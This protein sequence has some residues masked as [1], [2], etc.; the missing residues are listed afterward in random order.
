MSPRPLIRPTLLALG[1]IA[2]FGATERVSAQG[3]SE[4]Q[5]GEIRQV[6]KEYLVSNPEVIQEAIAE[7][8]RRQ[9]EAQRTAQAASIRK[10][11]DALLDPSTALV[12]GNPNGDVTLIEFS[13]YNCSYC[14]KAL[15][16][17]RTLI[18]TDPKLRIIIRDLEFIGGRYSREANV[19]ALAARKQ[20]SGD[21]LLQFHS[22]LL[23]TA[24]RVNGDRAR[25]VA[26]EV[27][28]DLAKLDSD[29]ASPEIVAQLAKN[30]SLA[31][32][33]EVTGTPA[34]VV[35]STVISGAVGLEP[36]R[37]AIAMTRKCGQATC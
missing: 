36:L 8:E 23:G 12:L 37:E 27:G 32:E 34:F 19:I 3:F 30:D 21:K 29:A 18:E 26:R 10:A 14:K 2:L 11:S 9:A 17:I 24:G 1:C 35:G 15:S 16:D 28:A 25:A 7:L 31:R 33:I 5:K 13:D 6:V 4:A 22:R 20:L